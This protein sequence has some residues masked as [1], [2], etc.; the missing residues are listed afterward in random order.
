MKDIF[1]ITLN[2]QI[3]NFTKHFSLKSDIECIRGF[4]LWNRKEHYG[5]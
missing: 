3:S 4:Y 1:F 5:L 2:F